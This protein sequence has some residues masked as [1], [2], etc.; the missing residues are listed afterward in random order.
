MIDI[1]GADQQPGPAP[2]RA[3]QAGSPVRPGELSQ[4]DV[5]SVI[6]DE[7]VLSAPAEPARAPPPLPEPSTTFIQSSPDLEFIDIDSPDD[8]GFI[9][10]PPALAPPRP[11]NPDTKLIGI[12]PPRPTPPSQE[13]SRLDAFAEIEGLDTREKLRRFT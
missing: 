1:W 2:E 11:D 7:R 8:F 12:E 3:A 4:T 6:I 13:A 9:D 10:A 5:D